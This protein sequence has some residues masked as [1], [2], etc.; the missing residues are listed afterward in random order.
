MP[1][2]WAR[3][4]RS[5]T[6]FLEDNE[7]PSTVGGATTLLT[8]HARRALGT[9]STAR[10]ASRSTSPARGPRAPGRQPTGTPDERGRRGHDRSTSTRSSPTYKDAK[11]VDPRLGPLGRR[12]RSSRTAPVVGRGE[13]QHRRRGAKV[14]VATG[15][16][17]LRATQTGD[18][19]RRPATTRSSAPSPRRHGTFSDKGAPSDGLHPRDHGLRPHPGGGLRRRPSVPQIEGVTLGLV[20]GQGK[21]SP[22]RAATTSDRPRGDVHQRQ[23]RRST[24]ASRPLAQDRRLRLGQ[25]LGRLGARPQDRGEPQPRLLRRHLRPGRVRGRRRPPARPGRP[26]GPTSRPSW[27]SSTST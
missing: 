8:T 24:S 1:T 4:A 25:R 10:P 11:G 7:D 19:G 3:P 17:V 15:Y 9:S 23:A 5:S 27:R 26:P 16:K 22:P 12:A 18:H 14:D 20:L 6:T 21:V 13:V 2:S